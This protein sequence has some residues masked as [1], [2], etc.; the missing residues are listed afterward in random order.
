MLVRKFGPYGGPEG[1]ERSQYFNEITGY[2]HNLDAKVV[3]TGGSLGIQF[4]RFNWVV[5]CKGDPEFYGND[6]DYGDS[7]YDVD[8][9][10]IDF[11]FDE[12]L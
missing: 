12:S 3:I 11:F 10:E 9:D 5:F 6:Y 8:S 1:K 7:I 4:L 2:V